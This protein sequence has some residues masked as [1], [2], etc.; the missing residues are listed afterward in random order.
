MGVAL[1]GASRSG[2]THLSG[3]AT[4]GAA[5]LRVNPALPGVRI[6]SAPVPPGADALG[7]IKD[8]RMGVY[9]V[10]VAI[11]GRSFT[12][13]DPTDKQR[14][15]AAWGAV[16]AGLG[17]DGS[18]IHRVQW[19]ERAMPGDRDGLRQYLE[20]EAVLTSGPCRDSY[21]ALVADAGPVGQHHD[22]L[23]VLAVRAGRR[24]RAGG[25]R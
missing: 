7:V 6:L 20:E 19:I 21:R 2:T 18:P 10:V 14:R 16:L 24:L 23:L 1:G 15:L 22:V 12:L 25:R 4:T 11:R 13:L 9:A 8:V 5:P 17:R 3:V